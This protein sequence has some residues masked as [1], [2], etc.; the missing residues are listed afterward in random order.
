MAFGVDH[1]TPW[2][3]A[4]TD[5]LK[6][7]N[8][9]FAVRYIT[10]S[11]TP[12]WT[13]IIRRAEVESLSQ[14]GINIVLNF[15]RDGQGDVLGGYNAG[16]QYAN[17]CLPLAQ[18]LG[19]PDGRPIIVSVDFDA[20]LGG[21]ATSP[22]AVGNMKRIAEFLHGWADSSAGWNSVGC[23][24]SYYVLDWLYKN[25]PLAIGWQCLAWSY[26]HWHPRAVLRQYDYNKWIGGAN[27]DYDSSHAPDYGQWRLGWTPG[28]NP[29]DNRPI[30]RKG[31]GMPPAPPSDDVKFLQTSLNTLK[32]NPQLDVD[33]RFGNGTDTAV[34]Q[35]QAFARIAA[36]GVIGPTTWRTIHFFLDLASKGT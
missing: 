27:C 29:W 13:K 1:S 5:A 20:T 32:A 19:Q 28:G 3:Q 23:Y 9:E 16:K 15:E 34:R 14:A 11:D 33:G 36:D 31:D 26:G 25:T 12:Y 17:M 2:T 24:G 10:G 4:L 22:L 6:A 35:F 30:L 21:T 8:V 7:S 18:A